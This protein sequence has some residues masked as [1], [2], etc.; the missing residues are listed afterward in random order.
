MNKA[1]YAL[2]FLG[3]CAIVLVV[4]IHDAPEEAKESDDPFLAS[5]ERHVVARAQ[6]RLRKH[7]M[8]HATET[9]ISEARKAIKTALL[10]AQSS[11]IHKM[12]LAQVKQIKKQIKDD[13]QK[14]QEDNKMDAL[15][16]TLN[17]V[18]DEVGFKEDKE[19]VKEDDKE[20]DKD[21]DDVVEEDEET[22]DSE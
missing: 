19:E 10:D 17:A 6:A 4:H 21:A 16:G 18:K 22:E 7:A 13:E 20:D 5:L 12:R 1:A 11:N 9:H 2:A 8:E 14:E 15:R 3:L